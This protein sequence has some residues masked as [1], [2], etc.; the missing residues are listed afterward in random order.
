MSEELAPVERARM[1]RVAIVRAAEAELE[2]FDELVALLPKAL[3]DAVYAPDHKIA[4][5]VSRHTYRC[6]N[7]HEKPSRG[8]HW[9]WAPLPTRAPCQLSV[10]PGRWRDRVYVA[11][12]IDAAEA[13]TMAVQRN[14]VL[15]LRRLLDGGQ[16]VGMKEVVWLEKVVTEC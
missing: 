8:Q 7:C 10:D 3:G 1:V 14:V 9:K 5:V 6:I 16:V 15:A 4:H 11:T 13:T 2:E 12:L